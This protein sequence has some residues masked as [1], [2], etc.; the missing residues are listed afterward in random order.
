MVNLFSFS[1]SSLLCVRYLDCNKVPSVSA[2]TSNERERE[3]G[4]QS[5]VRTSLFIR[6]EKQ[7]TTDR[8][9]IGF[10][11]DRVACAIFSLSVSFFLST[12]LVTRLR[13]SSLQSMCFVLMLSVVSA[14]IE[15]SHEA[16]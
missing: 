8:Q 11:A 5:E 14:P 3:K 15:R 12:T 6:L 7:R 10:A 13:D 2:R 9:T 16:N 4:S 1:S